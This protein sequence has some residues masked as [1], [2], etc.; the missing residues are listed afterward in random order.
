MFDEIDTM[1]IWS[2][3]IIIIISWTPPSPTTPNRPSNLPSSSFSARRL[4]ISVSKQILRCRKVG[5]VRNQQSHPPHQP[6][7]CRASEPRYCFGGADENHRPS[8]LKE[9]SS[10]R[11]PALKDLH[12]SF[13]SIESVEGIQWML[14]ESLQLLVISKRGITKATTRSTPSSPFAKCIAPTSTGSTSV[15]KI[16]YR[17]ECRQRMPELERCLFVSLPPQI[18]DFLWQS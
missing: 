13:N 4:S 7:E 6:M 11:F 18:I 15:T 14:L 17:W 9:V 12:L 3:F 1:N 8:I 2:I 10:I 16:L 5:R